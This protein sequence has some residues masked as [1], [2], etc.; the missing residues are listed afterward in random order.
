MK[1]ITMG[2]L[3]IPIRDALDGVKRDIQFNPSPGQ[4]KE[5]DNAERLHKLKLKQ[6]FE[7]T[8]NRVRN[9]QDKSREYGK[10]WREQNNDIHLK[11]CRLYYKKNK[12]VINEKNKL[13]V[14]TDRDK[15]MNRLWK[16]R[17]REKIKL[18]NKLNHQK[19]KLKRYYIKVLH[20][21]LSRTPRT[22]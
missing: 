5:L 22:P 19:K 20:E 10:N 7:L 21:L 2:N 6:D 18:T 12:E 17:N 13:R 3:K 8:K 1:C 14:K 16:E 4:Y 15:E 11:K 9:Y